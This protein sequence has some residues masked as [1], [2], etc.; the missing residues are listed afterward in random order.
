MKIKKFIS[1]LFSAATTS[2]SYLEMIRNFLIG[3]IVPCVLLVLTNLIPV[4]TPLRILIIIPIGLIMFMTIIFFARLIW[5]SDNRETNN[6]KSDKY[7]FKY[8]P[9]K[10]KVDDFVYW[11]KNAVVPEK[12]IVRSKNKINY[13]FE[14]SFETKGKNGPFYNKRFFL[15]NEELQDSNTCIEKLT[16]LDIIYN[17]ELSIYET[18]DKNSPELLIKI[19]DDL[20]I[21]NR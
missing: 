10:L 3:L 16:S 6:I 2:T 1:E 14:I 9:I 8:K 4:K 13:I 21:N 12:L 15:D 17:N 5:V 19:I 18:F 11:L 20:K 7:K